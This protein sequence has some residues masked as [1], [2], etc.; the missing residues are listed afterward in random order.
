MI[1]F[2]CTN[3]GSPIAVDRDDQNEPVICYNCNMRQAVPPNAVDVPDAIENPPLPPNN[4][5]A[6]HAIHALPVAPEYRL[7]TIAGHVLI[8]SGLIGALFYLILCFSVTP[9]ALMGVVG[10]LVTI[11]FGQLLHCIRDIAINTW[12]I[13]RK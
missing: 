1:E 12:N 5:D 13:S 10:S 6:P 2:R 3:C 9:M 8:V 7:V 11:G 4:P